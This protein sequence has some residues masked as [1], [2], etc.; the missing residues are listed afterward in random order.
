MFGDTGS[1]SWLGSA[2][3]WIAVSTV[4]AAIFVAIQAWY[5]RVQVVDASSARM[6]EQQLDICF[7]T[8]DAASRLDTEL[9]QLAREGSHA[10]VWPPMVMADSRDEMVRF[11][12]SVPPLLAHLE[13]GLMK[14]SVLGPLDRHRAFL[15]QQIAGLGERLLTLNPNLAGQAETD[16]Q[17][18]DI[19][20]ALSDFV[21]AQYL[22]NEGCKT[23][24]QRTS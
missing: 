22:V 16:A 2:T 9:R 3:F 13:N 1:N 12:T 20:A 19:F 8:F 7:D 18:K 17:V 6:L 11:Q 24:A 21:G 14:A 4:A 5:A 10:D 15:A 23:V